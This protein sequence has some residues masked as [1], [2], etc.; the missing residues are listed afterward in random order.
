MVLAAPRLSRNG[1][2]SH[3]H[4]GQDDGF[5]VDLETFVLTYPMEVL[6]GQLGEKRKKCVLGPC[7]FFIVCCNA[8]D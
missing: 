5:A 1:S 2:V 3:L 7:S 4:L 6:P 8:W